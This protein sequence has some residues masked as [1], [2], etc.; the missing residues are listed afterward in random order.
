VAC[1]PIVGSG[2][3]PHTSPTVGR[4]RRPAPRP[5]VTGPGAAAAPCHGW[6]GRCGAK[7]RGTHAPRG[8]G[9]RPGH[10]RKNRLA[11]LRPP[12]RWKPCYAAGDVDAPSRGLACT[13][14]MVSGAEVLETGQRPS[15]RRRAGQGPPSSSRQGPT[16]R[17][18][19]PARQHPARGPISARLRSAL[20]DAHPERL[21]PKD[22]SVTSIREQLTQHLVA[23]RRRAIE[24]ALQLVSQVDDSLG[25]VT[26]GA[27]VRISHAAQRMTG[28]R[29][30]KTAP[31][32]RTMRAAVRPGLDVGLVRH[33]THKPPPGQR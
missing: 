25:R 10:G 12:P 29:S 28:L 16:Y 15:H 17:R 24:V 26:K 7:R 19:R 18:R 21:T 14:A 1:R 2:E 9:H 33:V 3:G 8:M 32:F 20:G 5:T 30:P 13:L 27:E 6:Q 23:Q 31:R 4:V 11:G 22:F